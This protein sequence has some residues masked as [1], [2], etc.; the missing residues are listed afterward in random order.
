MDT[1][2]PHTFIGKQLSELIIPDRSWLVNSTS[3]LW[4]LGYHGVMLNYTGSTSTTQIHLPSPGPTISSF[5]SSPASAPPRHIV[6]KWG[7]MPPLPL[8]LPAVSYCTILLGVVLR[9]LVPP[10]PG[11]IPTPR[12]PHVSLSSPWST[13][14]PGVGTPP[15]PLSYPLSPPK[16]HFHA[17]ALTEPPSNTSS[18]GPA[19]LI[20]YFPTPSWSTP[21]ASALSSGSDTQTENIFC[22]RRSSAQG[23]G[24]HLYGMIPYLPHIIYVGSHGGFDATLP[25]CSSMAHSARCS[26]PLMG[27]GYCSAHN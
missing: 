12:P 8:W 13:W 20:L 18:H 10:P 25:V 11:D 17:V 2:N 3:T 9:L 26:T 1:L 5:G 16:S 14:P 4:R 27:L 6:H 19:T 7:S 21:T 23:K 22:Y 24:S 15:V